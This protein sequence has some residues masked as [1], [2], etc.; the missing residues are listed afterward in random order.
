MSD[1]GRSSGIEGLARKAQDLATDEN[2]DKAAE[3]IKKVAPDSA[4]RR[5]DEVAEQAKKHTR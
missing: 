5:V 3:A 2:V 1:S 4:D